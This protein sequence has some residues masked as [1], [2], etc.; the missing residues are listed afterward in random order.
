MIVLL[1]CSEPAPQPHVTEPQ[2]STPAPTTP[3]PTTPTGDTATAPDCD[4][5][6]EVPL[7][8]TTYEIQTTEDFDFDADG[9][10][11]YAANGALLGVDPQGN[12]RLV[13]M[14]I[15]SYAR[16]IQVLASADVVVADYNMGRLLRVD[17][18]TGGLTTLTGALSAPNG[19]EVA[20]GDVVYV[21]DDSLG[22]QLVH[23]MRSDGGAEPPI[24]LGTLRHPNGLA[25]NEAQD[26]MYLAD[27][28][29]GLY[30]SQRQG[31]GAW[32][33]PQRVMDPQGDTYSALEVDECGNVYTVEF[34]SGRLYRLVPSTGE[35]TLLVDLEDPAQWLWNSLRW[36]SD[37][38]GWR[39]DVL[40]VTNR[41]QL[42]G[43]ELGVR[44]RSQPIDP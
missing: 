5:L 32:G 44:G 12:Q 22:Q 20:D 41:H 3:E 36:G 27:L 26:T 39:R 19:L 11:V 4:D 37:V 38:G 2:P 13:A 17:H 23:A 40:Y 30:A 34:Y 6:P 21:T 35:I 14:G 42:F 25:L 43:V 15:G 7:S 31:D 33:T 9:W 28:Q 1:A 8:V 29:D 16:G 10:L 24:P 18:L